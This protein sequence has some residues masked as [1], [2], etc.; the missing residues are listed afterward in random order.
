MKIRD[1]IF[2]CI[3]GIATATIGAYIFL[4][5]FTDYNLFTDFQKL[6]SIG[7]LGKIMT[8]GAILNLV[9]FFTLLKLKKD[10]MARGV[11]FA[12]IILTIL[13]LFL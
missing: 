9:V 2:G 12:T 6:R 8:L 13:T 4:E 5:V 7:I 1:L 3:L 10:F 11:I